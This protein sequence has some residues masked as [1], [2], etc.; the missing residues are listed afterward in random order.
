MKN[1]SEES[2]HLNTISYQTHNLEIIAGPCSVES[3]KQIIEIAHAVKQAGASALRGGAFKPRTSPYDWAGL[4]AIG[5]QYLLKAKQETKLPIVTEIL[6]INHLELFNDIDII[7]VGARSM[8]NFELL[9][10][11]GK[12]Q[13]TILLKRGFGNTIKEWLLSA[14][15]IKS[16]GNNNIIMCERGIRSFEN[17]T[18]FRLDIASIPQIQANGYTIYIDPSHATGQANLVPPLAKAAVAAGANG[19][20]IECH[21]NPQIS[22]VDKE[23]ALRIEQ[24]SMLINQLQKIWQL[25]LNAPT[26]NICQS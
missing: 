18:R 13:K 15:Y 16:M 10:E 26:N 24:L 23:Q 2:T 17:S 11:L 9:K 6:S 22:K 14:E 12:T 3:E 21:T 25:E 4:G 7:Q 20:I 5:L 19:L 1:K 8:Q